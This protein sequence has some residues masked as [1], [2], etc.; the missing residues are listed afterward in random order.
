MIYADTITA[1][2]R[3]QFWLYGLI[4]IDH[5]EHEQR[6]DLILYIQRKTHHIATADG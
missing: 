1:Y 5:I 4:Q 2:S 6:R 3:Q